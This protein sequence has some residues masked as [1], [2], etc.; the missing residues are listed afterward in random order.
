[1]AAFYFDGTAGNDSTGDGSESLPYKT[2]A[3][4]RVG[5][6]T[7]PDNVE[8]YLKRGTTVSLAQSLFPTGSGT[9]T[10]YGSAAEAMPVLDR[11]SLGEYNLTWSTSDV[12]DTVRIEG[13]HILDAG[14]STSMSGIVG[15]S[16]ATARFVIKDNKVTGFNN[17]IIL[18][19]GD[20][21]VITGNTVLNHRNNGIIFEYAA[22]RMAIGASITDNY[23]DGRL[24]Y[25]GVCSNDCITL[26]T[27]A[28]GGMGNKI[29]GNTVVGGT[30]SCIEVG[31]DFC[32]PCVIEGNIVYSRQDGTSTSWSDFNVYADKAVVRN[33]LLFT[34]GLRIGIDVGADDVTVRNNVTVC[35]GSEI[36]SSS[37]PCIRVQGANARIYANA[38]AGNAVNVAAFLTVLNGYGSMDVKNNIFQIVNSATQRFITGQS[39]TP[40]ETSTI[41]YNYYIHPAAY[42]TCWTG[43]ITFSAWQART[44]TPDLNGIEAM[45]SQ[46]AFPEFRSAGDADYDLTAL[47]AILADSPLV[48]AG[49]H[50]GYSNDAAGRLR[51]NPPTIGAYEYSPYP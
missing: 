19:N 29:C 46:F 20:R 28:A 11:N 34:R 14:T 40:L 16:T 47:Y 18:Q 39:S 7:T 44:G 3:G 35:T 31:G 48:H 26:H 45:E 25:G 15:S 17:G 51:H 38:M 22:N 50:L 8:I 27:G 42:T 32:G 10:Y 49:T 9:L 37:Y 12:F 23:V 30:E 24:S 5:G 43:G 41:D 6:T 13:V 36:G 21:H 1:M 2:I 33:N 4:A